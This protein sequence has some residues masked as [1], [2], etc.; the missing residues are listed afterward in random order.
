MKS[1]AIAGRVA[2]RHDDRSALGVEDEAV[3]V[4]PVALQFGD[5]NALAL[6][7][8]VPVK[9]IEADEIPEIPRSKYRAS[10]SM[11]TTTSENGFHSEVSSGATHGGA[12]LWRDLVKS[13]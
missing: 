11:C 12:L 13:T 5:I 6:A 1:R 4:G 2:D 3:R 8:E 9:V 10:A 7:K